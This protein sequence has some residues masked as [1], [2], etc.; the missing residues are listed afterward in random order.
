MQS[1]RYLLYQK[2]GHACERQHGQP[3][4]EGC[5]HDYFHGDPDPR[6]LAVLFLTFSSAL[7]SSLSDTFL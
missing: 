5:G 6:F 2:A 3:G 4:H 1:F 7:R